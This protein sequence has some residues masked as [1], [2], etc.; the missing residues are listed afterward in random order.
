MSPSSQ[1]EHRQRDSASLLVLGAFFML[2][3]ILVV[4]GPLWVDG[5]DFP[6]LVN[7]LAAGALFLTGLGMCEIGRRGRRAFAPDPQQP[8]DQSAP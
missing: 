2:M 1:S 5:F 4:M 7:M 3:G 6:Q 8:K